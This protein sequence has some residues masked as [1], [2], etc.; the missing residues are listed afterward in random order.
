MEENDFVAIWLEE[1]GNP[2]IEELSRLNREV[3]DHMANFLIEKNLNSSDLS[4]LLDINHDE[5]AR[6]LDGMHAFSSKK[7]KEMS[8]TLAKSYSRP[9]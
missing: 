3:A 2:A 8:E 7:L 1:N 4:T 6:W 9:K 5:I